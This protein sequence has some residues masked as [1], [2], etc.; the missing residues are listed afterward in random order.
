MFL[1][2]VI[3]LTRANC[4]QPMSY[5][6]SLVVLLLAF[7]L[8]LL[9]MLVLSWVWQR[10][11]QC[12][13]WSMFFRSLTA[14]APKV[15]TISPLV[16]PTTISHWPSCCVRRA[17]N[18]ATHSK[19][20]AMVVVGELC[21]VVDCGSGEERCSRFCVVH[22]TCQARPRARRRATIAQTINAAVILLTTLK[23]SK[24]FKAC[25]FLLFLG[26]PG[27]SIKILKVGAP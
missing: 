23:W 27:V 8:V 16:H 7:K 1:A 20:V 25:F 24:V 10:Y 15:R 19:C 21:V 11:K 26:Y 14:K 6:T 18:Q 13:S 12:G 17:R 9:G 4:A 3:S 5:Y 22:A 2:D